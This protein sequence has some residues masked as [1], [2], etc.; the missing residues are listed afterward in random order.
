VGKGASFVVTLPARQSNP[1]EATIDDDQ[2][3]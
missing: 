2:P 1:R 3:E